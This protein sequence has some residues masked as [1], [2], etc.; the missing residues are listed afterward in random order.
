MSTKYSK[1]DNSE[2]EY[3][4]SVGMKV[5]EAI[6][7]AYTWK[8]WLSYEYQSST[9]DSKGNKTPG[10][11]LDNCP[12]C[13]GLGFLSV[14][15]D[16][17]SCGVACNVCKSGAAKRVGSKPLIAFEGTPKCDFIDRCP[18]KSIVDKN[19]KCKRVKCKFDE[20]KES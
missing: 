6:K 14:E 1:F 19:Y 17:Y 4:K 7:S 9:M 12:A 15:V 13:R 8:Y 10:P 11:V 5:E 16:G 20:R 3:P 2:S 18:I